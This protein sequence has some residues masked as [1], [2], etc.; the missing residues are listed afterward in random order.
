MQRPGFSR[1][2]RR[3]SLVAA[4]VGLLGAVMFGSLSLAQAPSGTLTI[5]QLIDGMGPLYDAFDPAHRTYR[6]RFRQ[7]REVLDDHGNVRPDLQ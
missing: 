5:D 2:G 7:E 1:G 4:A 3:Q 6:V